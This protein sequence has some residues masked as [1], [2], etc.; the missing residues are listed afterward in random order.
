MNCIDYVVSN[1]RI[2]MKD[3]LEK[4]LKEVVVV[5]SRYYPSIWLDRLSVHTEE[6]NQDLVYMV[7]DSCPGLPHRSVRRDSS[8][9]EKALKINDMHGFCNAFEY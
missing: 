8:E 6:V 4:T 1:V 3:E 7:R 2:I 5:Y 9:M